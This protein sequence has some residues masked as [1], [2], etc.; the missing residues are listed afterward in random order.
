MKHSLKQ[1][2]I[3]IRK[4]AGEFNAEM[5]FWY[6]IVYEEYRRD[7]IDYSAAINRIKAMRNYNGV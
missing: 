6:G 1:F 3:D 2:E 4:E 7:R 5:A